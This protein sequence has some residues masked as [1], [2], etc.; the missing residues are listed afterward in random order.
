[1]NMKQ[2]AEL[3]SRE[4]KSMIYKN[5]SLQEDVSPYDNYYQ[6]KEDEHKWVYGFWM[7]ER[8]NNP[9]FKKQKEFKTEEEGAKYF[10]LQT[11]STHY[12]FKYIEEFI[13]QHPE[14]DL[15]GDTFDEKRIQKAMDLLSIPSTL[16][17]KD[18]NQITNRAIVLEKSGD[19]HTVILFV[20]DKGETVKSTLP[21]ENDSVMFFAFKTVYSLYLFENKVSPLLESYNLRD[22]FTDEDIFRFF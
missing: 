16:L 4:G 14:L 17:A 3:L 18:K 2:A 10:F 13:D 5:N 11:L 8:Q 9:Y 6:L 7:V 12:F 21:I 15:D 20:N 1:M 22:Q 19:S